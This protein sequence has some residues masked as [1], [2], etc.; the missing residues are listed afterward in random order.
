MRLN[1]LLQSIIFR[2]NIQFPSRYKPVCIDASYALQSL[3]EECG[4]GGGAV[5]A[6]P[7]F[8]T[9]QPGVLEARVGRKT[10]GWVEHDLQHKNGVRGARESGAV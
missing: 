8:H 10:L 4:G 3:H 7:S 1:P 6:G 9:A 5:S 2:T